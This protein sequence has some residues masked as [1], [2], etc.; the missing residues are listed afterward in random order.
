MRSVG[1]LLLSNPPFVVLSST[2]VVRSRSMTS[3]TVLD[4]DSLA[5]EPA[6]VVIVSVFAP[7]S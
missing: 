6:S 1:A 2:T 5:E 3:S 7:R 4:E